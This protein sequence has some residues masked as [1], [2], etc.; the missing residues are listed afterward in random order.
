[1]IYIYIYI[2]KQKNYDDAIHNFKDAKKYAT[3]DDDIIKIDENL[4][5]CYIHEVLN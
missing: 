3:S 1:M 5:E 2:A 4:K